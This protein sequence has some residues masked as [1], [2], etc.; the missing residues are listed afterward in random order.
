M[1]NLKRDKGLRSDLLLYHNGELDEAKPD[2]EEI[3]SR[4]MGVLQEKGKPG[5][6]SRSCNPRDQS[7]FLPIPDSRGANMQP[8]QQLPK[9]PK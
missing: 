8:E 2:I 6:A 7:P 4:T 9:Q 5:E 1:N 3:K